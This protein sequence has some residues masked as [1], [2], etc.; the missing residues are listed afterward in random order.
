MIY[1]ITQANTQKKPFDDARLQRALRL[2]IDHKEFRDHWATTW[3]GRGRYSAIF[4]TSTADTWDL[5]EDEYGKLLEFKDPKD[6]AI[7]KLSTLLSAA[8]YTKDK[9]LKFTLSG[10]NTNGYQNEMVQLAQA[11]YQEVQPGRA[12]P[13]PQV[14]RDC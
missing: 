9:P 8:G 3:F 12:R 5:T 1:F 2:L 6:D 14:L 7:K 10:T 4:A 11:Q 13:G